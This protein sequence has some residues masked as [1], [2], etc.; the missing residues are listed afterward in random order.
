MTH[1]IYNGFNEAKETA[2]VY[3]DI[4]KAFDKVWRKGLL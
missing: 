3:L 2:M 4:A 1:R